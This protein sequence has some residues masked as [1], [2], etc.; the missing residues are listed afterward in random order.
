[1]LDYRAWLFVLEA[2]DTFMLLLFPMM[3]YHDIQWVFAQLFNH[4]DSLS[5]SRYFEHL[6]RRG[7]YAV[8]LSLA[9]GRVDSFE[10]LPPVS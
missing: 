7:H 8:I 10:V 3:G 5:F 1:M 4:V 6:R 9:C 2:P